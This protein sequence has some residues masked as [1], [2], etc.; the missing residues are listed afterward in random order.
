MESA[1]VTIT[2]NDNFSK[3]FTR[4]SNDLIDLPKV[5][6]KASKAI[7]DLIAKTEKA[8]DSFKTMKI[9]ITKTF[10]EINQ[11][12]LS[13]TTNR[14]TNLTNH[15]K[16]LIAEANKAAAA[17]HNVS[18]AGNSGNTGSSGSNSNEKKPSTL[19]KLGKAALSTVSWVGSTAIDAAKFAYAQSIPGLKLSSTTEQEN[20][21]FEAMLGSA[22]KAKSFNRELVSFTNNTPFELTDIRTAAKELLGAHMP[23]E[24]VVPNLTSIGN[25]ATGLGTGSQGFLDITGAISRMQTDGI[26]SEKEMQNLVAAG[27][28]AWDML[29]KKLNKT[30]EQLRSM[31][32]NG[33]LPADKAI[34]ELISGMN[35]MS[36]DAM[37]KQGQTLAG[38]FSVIQNTFNYSLLER[39]GDGIAQALQPRLLQL[40]NWISN[41]GA[42]IARWGQKIKDTAFAVTD[43][44]ATMFEGA[45][46]YIQTRYLNNPK[47]MK[48]SRKGKIDFIFTDIKKTFDAWYTAGG[49]KQISDATASLITFISDA[50]SG[51]SEQLRSI[52]TDLGLSIGSGLAEGIAQFAKDHPLLAAVLTFAAIPGGPVVKAVAAGGVLAAS[53]VGKAVEAS[54]KRK[55]DLGKYLLNPT[56]LSG[57]TELT[58]DNR[59]FLD[60]TSDWFKY[61]Y[62]SLYGYD[63]SN[64]GGLDRVPYNGYRAILHKDERVQTK[65]EADAWRSGASGKSPVQ[66]N[67]HYH[68]ERLGEDEIDNIMGIF[69]RK[70]EAV[71][72]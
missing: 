27:I 29:S 58:A 10:S 56:P 60:K 1:K 34:K 24:S 15:M 72:P 18:T 4:I 25:A 31:T 9:S 19:K 5:I 32:K 53:V 65:A 51:S 41:N 45:F 62:Y 6:G 47:F 8:S 48:L 40:A 17:I 64:A 38:L 42:T 7:D 55:E 30:T 28:P 23:A 52:G 63:G 37:A 50:L 36:S 54:D 22:D 35:D 71:S 66:F 13:D 3:N 46:N 11:R 44:L 61:Q 49:N 16:D 12:S 21:A 2:L 59:S 26:V 68:G 33:T 39:W 69:V 43:K 67:L 20:V 14:I 70:L 57:P